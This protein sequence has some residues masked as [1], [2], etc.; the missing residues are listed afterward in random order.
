[1]N[2]RIHT[3]TYTH[4]HTHFNASWQQKSLMFW[5]RRSCHPSMLKQILQSLSI[6][7]LSYPSQHILI[8]LHCW[9]I[10][11]FFCQLE[12][13]DKWL[14][15]W[16]EVIWWFKVQ[17]WALKLVPAR[18]IHQRELKGDCGVCVCV[19][20]PQCVWIC[21]NEKRGEMGW[22]DGAMVTHTYTKSQTHRAD[23]LGCWLKKELEEKNGEE[24]ER[25]A[26]N[27]H[28]P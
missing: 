28:W 12:Q 15:G 22:F 16:K 27:S 21:G 11:V 17:F 6:Q 26:S 8:Y 7:Y 25:T 19:C 10:D 3:L 5:Q 9:Y 18:V 23:G 1:M 4:K 2:I 14:D 13:V 24:I 20:T